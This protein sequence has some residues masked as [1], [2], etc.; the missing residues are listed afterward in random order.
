M[1]LRGTTSGTT[2][3]STAASARTA[4][5]RLLT[6]RDYTTAELRDK[7]ASREYRA[8]E[9]DEALV[10]LAAQGL[11]DDQ[12][13]AAAHVGTAIRIKGRGRLRIQRE[14]EARG[15]DR[16][17]VRQ[18]L[19]ALPASDEAAALERFLQRRHLPAHLAAADR[20][21]LFQQLLRRGFTAD[22]IARAIGARESDEE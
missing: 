8:E 6:R 10:N 3:A 14:L 12:R 16:G 9:I 11:L 18:A 13:A 2:S 1:R 17:V 4:A 7:L 22:L 21:R 19:E 20:R 15:L 5:L